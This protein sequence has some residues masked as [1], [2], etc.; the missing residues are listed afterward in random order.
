MNTPTLPKVVPFQRRK[1]QQTIKKKEDWNTIDSI[2]R[3]TVL[4]RDPRTRRQNTAN[5]EGGE[6]EEEDTLKIIPQQND[7]TTDEQLGREGMES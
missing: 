6:D 7:S 4:C 5:N 2:V 3:S 1:R